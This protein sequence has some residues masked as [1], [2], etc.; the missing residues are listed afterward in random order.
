MTR[1]QV[2]YDAKLRQI[3]PHRPVEDSCVKL[4]FFDAVLQCS[5]GFYLKQVRTW[6]DSL[7]RGEFIRWAD[8][9]D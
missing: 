6:V 7:E 2:V 4:D 9:F 3:L 5:A 8:V 1:L